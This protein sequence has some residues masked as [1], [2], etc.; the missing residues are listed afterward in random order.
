M[1][2]HRDYSQIGRALNCSIEVYLG[3]TQMKK[4]VLVLAA[5]FAVS[6]VSAFANNHEAKKHEDAQHETAKKHKKEEKKGHEAE[7][8]KAE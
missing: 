2:S 5:M 1:K 8:K 7:E 6:S 3:D 4:I